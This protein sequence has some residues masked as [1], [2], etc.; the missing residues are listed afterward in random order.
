MRLV[1]TL[2]SLLGFSLIAHAQCEA[3]ELV[4]IDRAPCPEDS[5][6]LVFHDEFDGAYLDTSTWTRKGGAPAPFDRTL[7][8]GCQREHQA[9]LEQNAYLAGGNLILEAK[10][11]DYRHE[12]IFIGPDPATCEDGTVTL[13]EPGERFDESFRFTSGFLTSYGIFAAQPKEHF[14]M[15]IRCKIPKGRGL[16][17]AFWMWNF[18]E[19]DVFE[20]FNTE[21]SHKFQVS[22]VD[23][24]KRR[25]PRR[26]TTHI[27]FSSGFYTFSV[28]VTDW[29]LNYYY[30]SAPLPHETGTLVYSA[31]KYYNT[32]SNK[33]LDLCDNAPP[34]E[35]HYINALFPD[36]NAW[37][38][39]IVNLAINHG[40]P[41]NQITGL[42][43]KF[44][45]DYIRVYKRLP[46]HHDADLCSV[47]IAGESTLCDEEPKTYHLSGH[48]LET[49]A[50]IRWE[51]SDNLKVLVMDSTSF[52]LAAQGGE[53]K[54]WVRAIKP[55]YCPE[56]F[57]TFDLDIAFPKPKAKIGRTALPLLDVNALSE[58]D[59]RIVMQNG[60]IRDWQRLAGNGAVQHLSADGRTFHVH[61][62]MDS[63]G[64]L[65]A[66]LEGVL[67]TGCP[68]SK[69]YIFVQ[70]GKLY[71]ISP[72]PAKDWL[73]VT[74]NDPPSA[75]ASLID[76][77]AMAADAQVSAQL[78]SL[79]V[80][81]AHSGRVLAHIP[82][83][84]QNSFAYT[85]NL[86]AMG[87]LP[88]NYMLRIESISGIVEVHPFIKHN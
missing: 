38:R 54:A 3:S 62:P 61:F 56:A 7:W 41:E 64:F 53:G 47:K 60:R 68:F 77:E 1:L 23:E 36:S 12:G 48:L 27:D 76:Y 10:R 57:Y 88:G 58:Q 22:Y 11:E 78:R 52:Q 39:P 9:Y 75:W 33:G 46:D 69:E 87:L 71:A 4:Y 82:V 51:F 31:Y 70:Y 19:I 43:A 73:Y 13:F 24:R 17:P 37:F 15:E 21:K 59:N 20:F 63:D 55:D 84:P 42:P 74:V 29:V 85:L 26:I 40:F 16:W 30:G 2:L 18:D 45:V 65:K 67:D 50:P 66:R 35:P 86:A 83:G 6:K 79:T 28:E 32:L 72:N 5:Y 8:Q 81:E 14:I 80:L 44:E 34:T 25:C 49:D